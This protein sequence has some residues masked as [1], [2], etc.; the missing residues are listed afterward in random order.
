[1]RR[2]PPI[3]SWMTPFPRHLEPDTPV[4]EARRFMLA[5]R[6]HH[7]PVKCHGG[8]I[9]VAHLYQLEGMPA[10]APAL[11]IGQVAHAAEPV[12]TAERVDRVV[13]RMA[14]EHLPVVVVVHHDRLAGI[15]TWTDACRHCAELL[16]EPF[17][18]P[19]GDDIA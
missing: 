2:I 3:S 17:L 4:A 8:G 12:D 19:G 7:V 9:A 14:Q 18:P 6:I 11:T 1:M 13:E 15:F 10:G 16:R 5:H